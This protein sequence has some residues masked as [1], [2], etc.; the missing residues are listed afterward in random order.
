MHQFQKMFIHTYL[1]LMLGIL[2]FMPYSTYTFFN[3]DKKVH[4][5]LELWLTQSNPYLG[6]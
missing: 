4:F 1:V 6:H 2:N 5:M 3:K